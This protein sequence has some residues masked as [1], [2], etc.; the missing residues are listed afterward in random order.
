MAEKDARGEEEVTGVV[1]N[2]GASA[3]HFYMISIRSGMGTGLL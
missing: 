3:T 2:D 1:Q